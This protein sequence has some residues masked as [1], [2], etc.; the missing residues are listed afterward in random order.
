M[1]HIPDDENTD[2]FMKASAEEWSKP[3]KPVTP[4]PAQEPTDRWGSPLPAQ[5]AAPGE[6]RWG[7]E[8]IEPTR[9]P[10]EP[11]EKNEG[12]KWWIIVLIVVLVLCLCGCVIAFGLPLLGIS[13][14]DFSAL[15]F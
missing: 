4:K 1:A 9:I 6:G 15:Q 11:K 13:I 10:K 12:K 8:P 5:P 3:E 14:L 2:D 7:S